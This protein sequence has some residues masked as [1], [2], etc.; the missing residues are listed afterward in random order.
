MG[1]LRAGSL[2]AFFPSS[3]IKGLLAAIGIILILKQTP[4]L[5]GLDNKIPLSE[6]LETGFNIH[7]GATVVGFF[8]LLLLIFWDKTIYVMKT[9]GL[10]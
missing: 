4:Y 3:V 9:V 7:I 5:F 6:L 1:W 10:L 2:A 8:S